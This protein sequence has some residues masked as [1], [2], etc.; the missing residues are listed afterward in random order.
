M[1]ASLLSSLT[2]AALPKILPGYLSSLIVD[3]VVAAAARARI[4][5]IVE[6]WPE[7][8]SV[9]LLDALQTLGQEHRVYYANPAAREISRAWCG[10]SFSSWT[11]EGA[12]HLR[13]AHAAGPTMI[14]CNHTSYLDTSATDALLAWS[15]NADLADRLVAIA[16]PKVYAELFRRVASAC[17]NTLPVPQSSTIAHAE[18]LPPREIARRAICSLEAATAACNAGDIPLLYAEGSRSRTG[19]L[20]SFLKATHRYLDLAEAISV[21]PT[22]I[23]GTREAM[24]IDEERLHPGPVTLRFGPALPHGIPP[25]ERLAAAH[26]AVAALLPEDHKPYPETPPVC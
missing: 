20:G 22:V 26:A 2:P 24:P 5:A 23:L 17:L 3:P 11:V 9:Q 12:E 16:G 14:V 7:E 18:P 21:V 15:G 4:A 8:T 10:A 1:S 19:H 13:A 25:R 6:A